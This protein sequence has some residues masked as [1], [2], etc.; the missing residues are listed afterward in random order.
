MC[1][2]EYIIIKEG[3]YVCPIIKICIFVT[4][5]TK[6]TIYEKTETISTTIAD[7]VLA[8]H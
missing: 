4:I 6:H 1:V 2:A 8:A 5:K 7:G 3:E